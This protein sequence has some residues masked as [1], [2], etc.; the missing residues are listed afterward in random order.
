MLLCDILVSGYHIKNSLLSEKMEKLFSKDKE[1]IYD[2]IDTLI[3]HSTQ[4]IR[5]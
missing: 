1:M 4:V 2:V 3:K 5:K